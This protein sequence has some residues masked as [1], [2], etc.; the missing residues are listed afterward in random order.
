MHHSPTLER[1]IF[2]F[3]TSRAAVQIGPK[4]REEKLS[5]KIDLFLLLSQPH[6]TV[7]RRLKLSEKSYSSFLTTLAARG[8]RS[9]VY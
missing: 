6:F 5:G 2:V 1:Y 8:L 3:E 9:Q 7:R 4:I